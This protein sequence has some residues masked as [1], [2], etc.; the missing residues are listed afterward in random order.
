M[1]ERYTSQIK[2]LVYG[3]EAPDTN[4]NRIYSVGGIAI[5]PFRISDIVERQIKEGFEY[6]IWV[7][8]VP[9]E[10]R[11]DLILAQKYVSEN[12]GEATLLWRKY[13]PDTII[14]FIEGEELV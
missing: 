2:S 6:E 11:T 1:S 10:I 13:R 12:R 14:Y 9:E 3:T 7:V 8:R 4:K 5:H